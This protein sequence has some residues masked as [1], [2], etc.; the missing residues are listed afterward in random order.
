[1]KL[2]Y[3]VGAGDQNLVWG[4]EVE[5]LWNTT[6]DWQMQADLHDR[7]QFLQELAATHQKPDFI[8]LFFSWRLVFPIALKVSWEN[9]IEEVHEWKM[10]MILL[11]DFIV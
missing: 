7:K 8:I 4:V 5:L 10:V 6:S 2:V 3:F 11:Q 1:M 9:R